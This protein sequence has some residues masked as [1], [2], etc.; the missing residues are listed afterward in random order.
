M[1]AQDCIIGDD[2]RCTVCGKLAYSK[3]VKR[4][5]MDS[6]APAVSLP[7]VRLG[8]AVE[9]MLTRIGITKDRV[10]Q[11]LHAK[12]CGCTARQNWL[13]RWGDAKRAQVERVLNKAAKFYFGR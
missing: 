5:C 6:A 7:R 3:D 11:F 12:D 4:N 8:D 13:N 9:S 10:R 1:T 2:L